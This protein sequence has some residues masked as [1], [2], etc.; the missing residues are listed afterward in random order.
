MNDFDK[1]NVLKQELDAQ[2]SQIERFFHYREVWWCR[3]GKNVGF[4][5]DGKGDTFARPV[6]VLRV[7]GK[8]TLLVAPLTTSKEKHFFRINVGKVADKMAKAVISQIRVI[9]ARRLEEY[10]NEKITPEA[11][12]TLKKAIKDLLR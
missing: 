9:D 12:N 11:M 4:E 8:D 2:E 1:W 6:V 5:Q 7:L 3:F 10:M